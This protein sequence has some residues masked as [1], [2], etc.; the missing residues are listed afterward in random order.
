MYV[1]VNQI[2]IDISTDEPISSIIVTAHGETPD[3]CIWFFTPEESLF[4][5]IY[6]NNFI[7]ELIAYPYAD[8]TCQNTPLPYSYPIELRFDTLEPGTYYVSVNGIIQ[9][10]VIPGQVSDTASPEKEPIKPLSIFPSLVNL[11]AIS[12]LGK[13][14]QFEDWSPTQDQIVLSRQEPGE[15]YQRNLFLLNPDG[16]GLTRLTDTPGIDM[17]AQWSPDGSQIV[18]AKMTGNFD[19]KSVV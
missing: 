13:D 14:L 10:F 15:D 2:D 11:S 17:M 12:G 5:S 9:P 19:R 7:I 1:T 18:F 6:Y 3:T 4:Q 8:A 16:S